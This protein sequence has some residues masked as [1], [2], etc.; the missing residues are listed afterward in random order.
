[1]T[2]YIWETS[3]KAGETNKIKVPEDAKLLSVGTVNGNICVWFL[4]DYSEDVKL[5]EREFELVPS[6]TAFEKEITVERTYIGT[7]VVNLYA[8]H[9]FERYNIKYFEEA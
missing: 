7:A 2:N 6:N 3:F 5:V 8:W 9:V 1:M 4:V